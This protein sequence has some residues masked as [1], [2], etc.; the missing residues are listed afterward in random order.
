M[1]RQLKLIL[2]ALLL[3]SPLAAM[4]DPVSLVSS[5][6][7]ALGSQ[8]LPALAASALAALTPLRLGSYRRINRRKDNLQ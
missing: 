8:V 7:L 6:V 5:A 2:G 3:V 1:R 4:A